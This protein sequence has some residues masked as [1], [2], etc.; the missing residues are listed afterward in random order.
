VWTIKKIA[1]IAAIKAVLASG[2]MYSLKEAI[3]RFSV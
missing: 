2:I 1:R 3:R